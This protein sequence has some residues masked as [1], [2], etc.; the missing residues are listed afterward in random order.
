MRDKS[1]LRAL[2]HTATAAIARASE[3]SDAAEEILND[4]EAQIFQLSEKRIGRGFMGVSEIV[5]ESFGSITDSLL[6]RGQRITGLA[7]HFNELDGMTCGLQR[8]DL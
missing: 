1:L 3:Q 2:I 5:R 8:A 4:T 7:T 6:Q